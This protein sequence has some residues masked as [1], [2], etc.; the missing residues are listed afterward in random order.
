MKLAGKLDVKEVHRILKSDPTKHKDETY[1]QRRVRMSA[2]TAMHFMDSDNVGTTSED[3]KVTFKD[4]MFT[5][6]KVMKTVAESITKI[7]G[8]HT[9]GGR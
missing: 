3:C 4:L 1:I 2:E 9:S 5:V 8:S 7:Y 6:T